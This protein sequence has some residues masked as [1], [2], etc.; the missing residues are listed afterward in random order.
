[1]GIVCARDEKNIN[2]DMA[3]GEIE[4]LAFLLI[5]INCADVLLLDF[6]Y[7]NI[8]EARLKYCYFDLRCLEMA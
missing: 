2:C 1:M 7:V 3:I 4:V 6:N 5:I 8:E